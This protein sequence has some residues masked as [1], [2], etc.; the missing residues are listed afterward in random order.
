MK[1]WKATLFKLVFYGRTL[2]ASRHHN[3]FPYYDD[4]ATATPR[5]EMELIVTLLQ[6]ACDIKLA[7]PQTYS[8]P[9]KSYNIPLPF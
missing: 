2:N 3:R 9:I 7:K 5:V 1:F 4:W 6:R 8:T